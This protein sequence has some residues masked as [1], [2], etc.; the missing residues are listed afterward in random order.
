MLWDNYKQI[1]NECFPFEETFSEEKEEK[2]TKLV[3]KIHQSQYIMRARETEITDSR[4]CIYNNI[5]YPKTGKNLPCFGMDLMGFMEKKV[6]IVFDF[7]HPKEHY[8]FNDPII[9][10]RM[11]HYLDNTDKDIRFFEPGNHFSR[12]IFVRKCHMDQVDEYLDDFRTY[13]EAYRLLLHTYRPE[14]T[15]Y[16]EYRDFD[17]YMRKLDP[18]EGYLSG[19]FGKEYAKLYVENFL[20]PNHGD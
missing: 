13:V 17:T 10:G 4:G 16:S 9:R 6:I 2:D 12:Y 7:Q 5:L 20:F 14:E 3:S 15:E 19:K 11:G 18:V 8:D 1:L